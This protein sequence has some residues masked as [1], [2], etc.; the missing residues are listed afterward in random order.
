MQVLSRASVLGM[1]TDWPM[2]VAMVMV[3]VVAMAAVVSELS[4]P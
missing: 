1:A 2:G 4:P 3:M